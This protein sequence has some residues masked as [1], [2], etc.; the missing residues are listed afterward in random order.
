MGAVL[1]NRGCGKPFKLKFE[2]EMLPVLYHCY[3]GRGGKLTLCSTMFE[4]DLLLRSSLGRTFHYFE[5]IYYH[6]P[7]F[8]VRLVRCLTLNLSLRIFV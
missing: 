6:D 2:F 1:L 5:L 8:L 4:I 3:S 7:S